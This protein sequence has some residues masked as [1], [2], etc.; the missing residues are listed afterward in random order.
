M[1]IY[2]G[3]MFLALIGDNLSESE[4]FIL[5]DLLLL[6]SGSARFIE[7]LAS[8]SSRTKKEAKSYWHLISLRDIVKPDD[9]RGI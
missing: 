1:C 9:L 4:M 6:C 5:S 7:V 3:C 8:T 2:A